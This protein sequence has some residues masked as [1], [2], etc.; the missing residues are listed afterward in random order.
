MK[1]HIPNTVTCL[2]LFSG[3]LGIVFAFNGNLVFAS[4]AILIAA[5]LD[6]LDGMLA[7]LL[8]AYSELGKQ[9]DSLADMV[10]FGVLPSVIIYHLFLSS[11]EITS[12]SLISYS[13]FIIAVFSG[14][15]LAKFNIDTRQSENF[16]GLPTPA[17]ALL[18]ASFPFM[19]EENNSFFMNYIMNPYSL[20][21][22]SLIMSFLLISEIP[23]ISLKFKT[24]SFSE[25]ALRYTLILSSILLILLLQFAAV[26]IILILYILI[27]LLQFRKTVKV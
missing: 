25:N 9:L 20:L 17:N 5:V 10:S 4:Y 26:P 22:F 3:C 2:N 13:A 21:V 18:I 23:L 6:F 7:R 14:L 11:V 8:K 15:R 27:S 12:L 1:Q 16:I 24:L 19:M